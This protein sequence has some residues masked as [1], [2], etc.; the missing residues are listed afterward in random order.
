MKNDRRYLLAFILLLA[1]ITRSYG[2]GT[3]FLKNDSTEI[4]FYVSKYYPQ[5]MGDLT[6]AFGFYHGAG[7][8]FLGYA[9]AWLYKALSIPLTEFMWNL[10]YA[11]IGTSTILAVY[12][13][14]LHFTKNENTALTSSLLLSLYPLHIGYSRVS[15]YSEGNIGLL[16]QLATITLFHKHY[17]KP[18][19]KT[20][21]A[22][23]ISLA[24]LALSDMFS[25]MIFPL[26]L[27][28]GISA[29]EGKTMADSLKTAIRKTMR[30]EFTIP[31]LAILLN[32]AVLLG[33]LQNPTTP[34]ITAGPLMHVLDRPDVVLGFYPKTYAINLL[35][36][37]GPIMFLAGIVSL[38]HLAR[39]FFLRDGSN[40]IIAWFTAY[41]LPFLFMFPR[42]VTTYTLFPST[43][44]MILTSIALTQLLESGKRRIRYSAIT[45]ITV[46]CLSLLAN[47]MYALYNVWEHPFKDYA[48]S[49]YC[50]TIFSSCR[51]TPCQ[52]PMIG[53]MLPDEGYKAA[54]YWIRKN[55]RED[56]T[57]LD[58]EGRWIS[59]RK[60]ILYYTRRQLAGCLRAGDSGD[61]SPEV[62]APSI[63]GI[64]VV[65]S[66][67]STDFMET[68]Y[69]KF[70]KTLQVMD[71]VEKIL[72]V[73][74]RERHYD[75]TLLV[76]AS[77]YN[78]LYD[79]EYADPSL[80]IDADMRSDVHIF[81]ADGNI[82]IP[83]YFQ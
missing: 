35:Y 10:P 71:G 33:Y 7:N 79:M 28:I 30:P 50:T 9:I 56:S 32:S 73:Y 16:L 67:P 17:S 55:T 82:T 11:L 76:Q 34:S 46:I 70:H 14:T 65:L 2:I 78:R 21:I 43:P 83:S 72:N 57:I 36:F 38:T 69:K 59:R 47:D 66:S 53:K 60:S 44:L 39:R 20:A 51:F 3:P 8:V 29:S 25:P 48:A 58:L 4:A 81:T 54:G 63:G 23:A 31:L 45:L 27:Y 24:M 13:T 62:L 12:I 41:S 18:T 6:R 5:S 77:E 19:G 15:G 61:C 1:F 80:V 26:I 68:H 74:T 52:L 75:K 40:V 49:L 64:D 22:A 37:M 42:C